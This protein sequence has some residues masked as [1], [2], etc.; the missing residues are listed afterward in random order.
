MNLNGLR[1]DIL[2]VR[3]PFRLYIVRIRFGKKYQITAF[4]AIF[5]PQLLQNFV[6]IEP[7]WGVF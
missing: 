5:P 2:F 1:H 3:R 7:P 4:S 6:G